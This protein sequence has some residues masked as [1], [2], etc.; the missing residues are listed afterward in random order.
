MS[1]EQGAAGPAAAGNPAAGG[2][3]AGGPGAAEAAAVNPAAVVLAAGAQ[4]AAED[5]Q[6]IE[7][8]IGGARPLL[9][10]DSVEVSFGGTRA[11]GGVT[12]EVA[13]GEFCGLIG[14]NGAGKSTLFNV[15]TGFV[16]PQRGRVLFDGADIT[17][18]RAGRR[19][20]SGIRRTFQEVELF[21]DLTVAEN[22][23]VAAGSKGKAAAS[24]IVAE[25][26]L[27]EFGD[28]LCRKL[29]GGIRRRV[30][31]ARALASQPRLLLLDEPG[32]GL[33]QD[34][35]AHLAQLIQTVCKERDTTVVLV[36]HDM[37]LIRRVCSRVV[38]LDFGKVIAQGTPEQ[39]EAD[40]KVQI[41]YLGTP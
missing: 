36:D 30:G 13:A 22:V 15:V 7:A 21:D 8:G 4:A 25:L 6:A 41:A 24:T 11:L 37:S 14:P 17:R 34:E 9:R 12:V 33:I 16:R 10:V 39:I 31:V 28:I 27:T 18:Q 35:V 19:S 38:V 2:L 5:V 26:E 1:G 40:E 29:P 32:A 20:R 23:R 3:A